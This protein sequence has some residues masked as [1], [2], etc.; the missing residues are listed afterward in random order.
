[1]QSTISIDTLFFTILGLIIFVI[2][3]IIFAFYSFKA[4]SHTNNQTKALANELQRQF[5]V[6]ET[7]LKHNFQ[8]LG[9]NSAQLRNDLGQNIANFR[10]ENNDGRQKLETSQKDVLERFGLSQSHALGQINQTIRDLLELNEKRGEAIRDT[11]TNQLTLLR[12]E[13]EEKL[14][15]MRQTVDEKL[16]GTLEA[17]LGESFKMVSE[18]LDMVHKGLGEM[19]SLA[20]GVG[21]L[22]RVLTN[23]KSR[24]TWGEVQ[25]EMLLIDMLNPDQF[26]KNAR[27]NPEKNGVVEF[28]IKLPGKFEDIPVYLPIDAKFPQED[29]ERLV[30]AQDNGTPEDIDKAEIALERAIRLQAKTIMDKYIAPPHTTDFAIMFLPTEGLFAEVVRKAGFTQSL[31]S[32][33][34]IMVT[35]PT[36]LAATLSS[37]QMG[38]RTLA[39]EKRSSEVWQILGAA[40]AE[41]SKYGEVWDKLKKQLESAQNTVDQAGRRTRVIERKLR[42]VEAVELPSV[43]DD[44]LALPFDD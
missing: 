18:R 40:K 25:L 30:N 9:E 19:Q 31:Q 22:K 34:R 17:R 11:L 29:Y 42:D 14:E 27:V 23:V 43:A 20:T 33:Y 3:A 36:T 21:D 8:N 32:E 37:L 38:F 39:I 12:K 26:E 44:L 10:A 1:M 4:A 41:F 35:G 2:I 6:L 24:G 28:A 16:Q 5:L 13:N 15:K 7:T